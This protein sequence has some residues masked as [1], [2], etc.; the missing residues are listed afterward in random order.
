MDHMR[1]CHKQRHESSF[2]CV[3]VPDKDEFPPLRH[4]S[5]ES[6]PKEPAAYSLPWH[7]EAVETKSWDA[8]N[9]LS[10]GCALAGYVERAPQSRSLFSVSW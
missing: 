4:W 5:L 6:F 9:S 1:P 8:V 10:L 7:W 3:W 2:F